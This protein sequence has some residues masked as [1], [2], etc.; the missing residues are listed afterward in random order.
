MNIKSFL[1]ILLLVLLISCSEAPRP[2]ILDTDW[3]TDVDDACALRLLLQ[4][5]R[6]GKIDL[7]G[8]CLSAVCDTSVPSISSFL[9]YEGAGSMRIGADIQ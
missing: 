4:Q 5:E 1:R 6:E 2:V 8:V 9:E 3:W 7:L